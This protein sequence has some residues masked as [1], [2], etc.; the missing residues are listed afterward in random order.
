M[1][2]LFQAARGDV[3]P[4]QR[5]RIL[6]QRTI[7]FNKDRAAKLATVFHRFGLRPSKLA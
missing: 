1:N 5:K 3:N 6:L 7:L 2:T 4:L